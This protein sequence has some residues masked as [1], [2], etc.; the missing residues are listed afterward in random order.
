MINNL[1][2]KSIEVDKKNITPLWE[3]KQE[4]ECIIKLS[5][6][7]QSKAFDI[8]GQAL[9]L[10]IKRRDKTLVE[11]SDPD[12]FIINGNELD[13][14]LKNSISVIAG[15]LECD[16]ELSDS[17]G[18]MTTASFFITVKKKVLNGESVQATNEF[19]TFTKTVEK[20]E[21]DY[22]SLKGGLLAEDKV[23]Y[24]QNEINKTNS[25]LETQTANLQDQVNQ[26]NASLDNIT[27]IKNGFYDKPKNGKKI[28][29]VGDSTTDVATE[30]YPRL[31]ELA[32]T[33]G[34]LEGATFIN[35]GSSGNTVQRF[36][37]GL[38]YNS[39]TITKVI[40]DHADLYVFCYGINDIRSGTDSP[41][42]SKE[43]IRADIK[44]A[45]DRLLTETN[46]YIL[47][48]TPNIFL[49]K[50]F[51]EFVDDVSN[52]QKYT[53]TLWE[54]YESFRGYD[55]RVDVLDIQ[56]IVFGRKA[57]YQ[58]QYMKDTLHPNDI[59]YRL[60][61]EVIAEYI[62][63][64]TRKDYS[65]LNVASIGV[66]NSYTSSSIEL[67]IDNKL[68][69]EV[70]DY[71][72]VGENVKLNITERPYLMSRLY[73][74]VSNCNTYII[75][76]NGLDF[77][78]YGVCRLIKGSNKFKSKANWKKVTLTQN[79]TQAQVEIVV[80]LKG[81]TGICDIG[82]ETEYF[83]NEPVNLRDI[84]GYFFFNN[85]ADFNNVAGGVN[86]AGTSTKLYVSENNIYGTMINFDKAS[87][88][89]LHLLIML[90]SPNINTSTI[91]FRNSKI[92][93]NKNIIDL[94][95]N[96]FEGRAVS[97]S[98]VVN[99][100]DNDVFSASSKYVDEKL[101][102]NSAYL[103]S[104]KWIDYKQN[105]STSGACMC[106]ASYIDITDITGVKDIKL[107]YKYKTS[108]TRITHVYGQI[109][110]NTS[111]N[112][113]SGGVNK[114][115]AT[116]Q[117]VKGEYASYIGVVQADL[118]DQTRL[119]LLI[120]VTQTSGNNIEFNFGEVE[121]YI[122]DTKIDMNSKTW[123]N[124]LADEGSVLNEGYKKDSIITYEVLLKELEK[125]QKLI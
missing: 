111:D 58:H 97:S 2:R 124:Y 44:T 61:G 33:G 35:R 32:K 106:L 71:I 63:N 89:Y 121:L 114:G 26:T 45:L 109:V 55:N 79:G 98:S 65:T 116:L 112:S 52:C 75:N 94:K 95:D 110:A 41:A 66:I 7:R 59:G 83:T 42:R 1:V 80:D 74:N 37:Q 53:D 19:D 54:I 22:N 123:S 76:H 23:V 107:R 68:E 47:L 27:N 51:A 85:S 72:L 40:E 9:R 117:V 49:T 101:S 125:Y 88:R 6:Y 50:E 46:G 122:G 43:Q 78:K 5:L 96:I 18:K 8:I 24:F 70:G 82:F 29:F 56:S 21:E 87:Y 28:V 105:K 99:E 13:I 113:I 81:Y 60:I 57:V 14:K 36:I 91:K 12:S 4:D 15:P 90:S 39:N 120:N 25:Q 10:G 17:T 69:L 100:V 62:S 11:V 93:I 20:I 103:N 34:I 48:R 3:I 118:T 115:Y 38:A 119:H 92:I 108:D 102:E 77:S 16:L 30:M 64:V 86:K 31:N 104:P 84:Q 67:S 73:N